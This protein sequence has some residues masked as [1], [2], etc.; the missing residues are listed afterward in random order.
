[1]RA[2]ETSICVSRRLKSR[3]C[4]S[5]LASLSSRSNRTILTMRSNPSAELDSSPLPES[6]SPSLVTNGTI[7]NGR[8]DARS[9]A[10][11]P[12]R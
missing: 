7:Q 12:R 2:Y 11:H 6:S 8:M 9:T 3:D 4:L 10:N 5:T 1:M